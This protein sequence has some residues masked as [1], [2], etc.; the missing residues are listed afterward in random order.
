[1]QGGHRER[2][3]GKHST[4]VAKAFFKIL[5]KII[6]FL[7][8][9][10]RPLTEV[11]AQNAF[12]FGDRLRVIVCTVPA[13]NDTLGSR[14]FQVGTGIWDD[15]VRTFLDR[16]ATTSITNDRVMRHAYRK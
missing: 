2:S 4:C 6:A 11:L 7:K 3:M 15:P 5:S 10:R 8:S 14:S 13:W 16:S 1:M 12:Q 9:T